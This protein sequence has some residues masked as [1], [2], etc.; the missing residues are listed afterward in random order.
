MKATAIAIFSLLL[1]VWLQI[2]FL[3]AMRPL[4]I[5]PN[6]LLVMLTYF[7]LMRPAS[8]ALAVGV[9][10]GLMLDLASGADFGIRLGFYSLFALVV[11]MTR[12]LG[13]SPDS[14]WTAI[15]LI[16]GGTVAYN[17]IVL[18]SLILAR[19]D[20]NFAVIGRL[21]LNET[22]INLAFGLVLSRFWRW[23]YRTGPETLRT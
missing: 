12:Q 6:L 10:G 20:L 19:A 16:V 18:A 7:A 5:L 1:I 22:L 15:G 17:L 23:L 8:Q 2:Y 14:L 21:I 13:G 11:V 3:G 9:A 4:G